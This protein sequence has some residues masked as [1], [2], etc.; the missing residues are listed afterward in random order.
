MVH[1]IRWTVFGSRTGLGLHE[2]KLEVFRADSQLI[3][4]EK[5]TFEL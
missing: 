1:L 4:Y 5:E 2:F 3:V